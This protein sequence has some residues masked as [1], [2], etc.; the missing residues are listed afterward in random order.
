MTGSERPLLKEAVSPA[1]ETSGNALEASNA[2]NCRAWG[3]PAVLSRGI[4][5]IALRAL[6]G[7]F[8]IF[9]R[10]S[11]GKSQPYW[12]D[13]PKLPLPHKRVFFSSFKIAPAVRVVARQLSGKNCLAA[14]FASGHQDASPGP[15]G[16]KTL[17]RD[18]GILKT[19]RVMNLLLCGEFTTRSEFTTENVVSHYIFSS[20]V[21][22]ILSSE[23]LCVVNSLQSSKTLRNR[24]PY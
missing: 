17:P 12:G 10:I 5:G 18:P 20:D 3:I 6:A 7:S 21:L 11:S 23:S 22:Y 15:L 4:Q 1:V 16:Y 14:S 8:R 13:G 19:V 9:S 2:L 24:T